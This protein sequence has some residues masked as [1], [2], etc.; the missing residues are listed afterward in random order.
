ME[1]K[2]CTSRFAQPVCGNA[3]VIASCLP[4]YLADNQRLIGQDDVAVFSIA[5]V[6]QKFSLFAMMS[7][8]RRN[9]RVTICVGQ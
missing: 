1:M 4:L 9:T 2:R 7:S 5:A 3:R 6:A 8:Q